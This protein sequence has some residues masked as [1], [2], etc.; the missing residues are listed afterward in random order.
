MKQKIVCAEG[1][2]E[3]ISAM[4][5]R[6]EIMR[7]LEKDGSVSVSIL[8]KEFSVSTMTIRRDLNFFE[9]Q[10]ILETNY[11]GAHIRHDRIMTPDFILRNEKMIMNKRKIGRKAVEFLKD[12]DT[13]FMDTGTTVLQMAKYFPD[14]H[15]TIITN[16]LS[17]VQYMSSNAK[18]KIILAPGVYREGTGGTIDCDTIDFLR[19]YYVDK[20]FL[21]AIACKPDFGATTPDEID[22]KIKQTMCEH[23]E[24]SFLLV[25]H[26]KFLSKSLIKYNDLSEFS[27][28]LTDEEIEDDM[29]KDIIKVNRELIIC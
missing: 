16:S 7:R 12:G 21:G 5:R 23:S 11:G 13:I 28:I 1:Q 9:K 24:A 26:T 4:N 8:A 19:R 27:Y 20:A 6:R 3:I 14:I 29:E 25:D 15:G 22:A 17:I 2:D 18:I 10:G